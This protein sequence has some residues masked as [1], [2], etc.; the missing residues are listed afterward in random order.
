LANSG[1]ITACLA[2]LIFPILSVYSDV[3]SLLSKCPKAFFEAGALPLA[4]SSQDLGTF[5]KGPSEDFEVPSAVAAVV[6]R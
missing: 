3:G 6:F 4:S 5:A 2:F 1:L